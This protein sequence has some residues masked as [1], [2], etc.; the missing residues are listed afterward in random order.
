MIVSPPDPFRFALV[1]LILVVNL[2]C[3]PEKIAPS[4]LGNLFGT[5]VFVVLE[6]V[7]DRKDR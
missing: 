3:L 1:A 6:C 7:N 5:L 2:K 4:D